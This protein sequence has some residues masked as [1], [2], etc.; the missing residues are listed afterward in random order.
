TNSYQEIPEC[1][2]VKLSEVSVFCWRWCTGTCDWGYPLSLDGN[3]YSVHEILALTKAIDF[4][5]P[6]TYES[7]LQGY[8]WL[9]DHRYGICFKKSV[10]VNI[11][12]NRVQS[13]FNNTHG[14]I[15]QDYLL[16]KWEDGVRIDY[17]K[18]YGFN[19]IG[20]HQEIP[21]HFI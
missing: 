15:H 17:R 3:L 2:N 10:I 18:L 5:S 21:I 16:S 7:H 19:N 11:P 13:D 8:K 1:E 6:N 14:E 12:L 4:N 20:V 9:F